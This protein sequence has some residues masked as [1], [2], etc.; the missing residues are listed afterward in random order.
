MIKTLIYRILERR[1]YWRYVSF[2]EI[3]ELY[4]S[5]LLRIF[6][7]AMVSIFVAVYLYQNGYGLTF[8]AFFFAGYYVF[9]ALT[10]YP[11]A[12]VIARIGPKHATLLSNFLYIPAMLILVT[13]PELGIYA[14]LGFAFLQSSS[15]SLYEMAYLVDFSKIK[16]DDH[17]GKEIGYMHMLEQIARGS[18]PFVGGFIAYWFGPQM[19]LFVAATLF[20]LSAIPLFF[21]PEPV[22]THQSITFHG[23]PWKRIRR[24]MVAYAAVGY[25]TIA[26]SLL[27]SLFI[28]IAIFGINSNTIYAQLGVLATLTM[29][30][31]ILSA[32]IFGMI[33][34]RTKG[35]E[36]LRV[37]VFANSLTHISRLFVATPLGVVFVNIFN[38]LATTGFTLPFTKGMFALADDLP[39]YRIAF[40]SIMNASASLGA[41]ILC[42]LAG[43]LSLFFD[44]AVALQIT[45][46]F[47]AVAVLGILVHRFPAL[48]SGKL[49]L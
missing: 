27:W 9:R 33:V 2:S 7:V 28:A 35:K 41:A 31:G 3:A 47:T 29:I 10:S 1:H 20:L 5:R 17:A 11:F 25:D 18:S 44:E 46:A 36:L 24:P 14:I 8:I 43:V 26:S 19:T 16:H 40:I 30:T 13:L 42:T 37:G 15:L 6:G 45:Y 32:K 4:A 21:T 38:E 49:K 12:Y 23:I 22:K 48:N 39:G 34:D